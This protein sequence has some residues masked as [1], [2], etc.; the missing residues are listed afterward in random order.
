VVGGEGGIHTVVDKDGDGALLRDLGPVVHER[1]LVQGGGK[2]PAYDDN[3]NVGTGVGGVLGELDCLSGTA[4]TGAGN[5]GDVFQGGLCRVEDAARGA[6][7]ALSLVGGEVVSLAHGAAD[8]EPNACLCDAEH[9]RLES[10]DIYEINVR[11]CS[12][13]ECTRCT[14]RDPLCGGGR[15]WGA[16]HIRLER[17]GVS[18]SGSR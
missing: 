2:V 10:G 6:D 9:M 5:E 8:H 15:R 7:E 13:R 11:H 16:A 4:R 14:D 12:R 18:V 3:G 1:L 17:R